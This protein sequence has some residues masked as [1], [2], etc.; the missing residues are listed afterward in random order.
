MTDSRKRCIQRLQNSV[1]LPHG[2]FYLPERVFAETLN[3]N[4][5]AKTKGR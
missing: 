4:E 3:I 1:P 2:Q 5:I